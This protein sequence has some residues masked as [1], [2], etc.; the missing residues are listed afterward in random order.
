LAGLIEWIYR[1]RIEAELER[2]NADL[3][4]AAEAMRP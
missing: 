4:R 3:K 1:P 2:M